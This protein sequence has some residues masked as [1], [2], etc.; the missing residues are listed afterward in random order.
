MVIGSQPAEF[1]FLSSLCRLHFLR[2]T[3]SNNKE[4]EL[5][6][7]NTAMRSTNGNFST[8]DTNW[9]SS[10]SQDKPSDSALKLVES[11]WTGPGPFQWEMK[12]DQG[13]FPSPV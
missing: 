1:L 11:G 4:V 10:S 2:I 6:E 13:E 5:D 9:S 3:G 12:Q 7:R 8:A